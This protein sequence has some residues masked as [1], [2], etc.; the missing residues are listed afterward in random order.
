[1]ILTNPKAQTSVRF[2]ELKARFPMDPVDQRVHQT[3]GLRWAGG[4]AASFVPTLTAENNVGRFA[5]DL[6]WQKKIGQTDFHAAVAPR[7]EF[8]VDDHRAVGCVFGYDPVC[9]G[10]AHSLLP[11]DGGLKRS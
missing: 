5:L 10:L 3:D 9:S 4:D 11:A 7:T 8:G 2:P 6:V 1:M